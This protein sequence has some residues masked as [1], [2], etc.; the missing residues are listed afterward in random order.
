MNIQDIASL[1][2]TIINTFESLKIPL[3]RYGLAIVFIWFGALKPL[4]LS[5]ASGLVAETVYF[6]PPELFVPFLGFWEVIIGLCF[7]YK[8]LIRVGILLLFLQMAGTF[9]PLIILP[10]VTFTSYPVV[11]TLE[12]QYII[13]NILIIA[14]AI[15]IG[16]ELK[17]L[18]NTTT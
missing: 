16:S 3:L 18:K 2:K 4:G 10:A 12:G 11:P 17:P 1:D 8:P 6:V 5:S 7:L 9:L 13:K 14:A 15:T